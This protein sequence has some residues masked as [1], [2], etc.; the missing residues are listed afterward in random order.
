MI[1]YTMMPHQKILCVDMKSFYASCSAVMLGLDPLDCY[2]VVA[3]N[4]DR[5]GSVVLAASPRMKKEFGIKTGSR[6]FEVP[7]DPRIIVEEPKMATYLR[8]STEITRVFHR[9]VPKEAI[10]TYSVDESFIKVDGAQ[11]LWGDAQT[12][13]KKIKNDIEREFQLPSA[14]GIGPNMLMAKLCL[15][16]EAKHEGVAEWTYEDVE[17]KLWSVSPLSKMWGIGRRMEK[18]LN[19]IGIFTVGQLARYDL[20]QLEKKFGVMGNQLYYHAWGVDLSEIGAPILQGQISFGKSQILLRDYKDEEEI[21]HVILEM[22]EEVARRTRNHRKAAR[23]INFGLGYSKDEFGGGFYRSRT[24]EEPTNVTMEIYRTCL[25]LF[26]EHY[27]GKTVRQ[28]SISLSNIVDDYELQLSLFDANGWKRRKLGYIVD[29][30]R[31]RF[32]SASL[33]RAVS[34]TNA[35]TARHRA[36][37]VGGHKQ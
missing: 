26:K 8:V 32:G 27:T 13:A 18:N 25:S 6:L 31:S 20:K 15:D 35:G 30:I 14:I 2:L 16:L 19:G 21:K 4:H 10:H 11:Q 24:I 34:Y 9:Y 17:A 5:K 22:C 28:I 7:D 23:T 37:L 1:D 29:G 36:T 33:L 3:G 12:I